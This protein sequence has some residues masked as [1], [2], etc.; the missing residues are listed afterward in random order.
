MNEYIKKHIK[1]NTNLVY[2]IDDNHYYMIDFTMCQDAPYFTLPCISAYDLTKLFNDH[3][4]VVRFKNDTSLYINNEL[5]PYN[6]LTI[7]IKLKALHFPDSF[8]EYFLDTCNKMDVL[9]KKKC[10]K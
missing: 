5:I 7:S 3:Y 4:L 8:I 6:N 1:A 2:K 10:S 9:N